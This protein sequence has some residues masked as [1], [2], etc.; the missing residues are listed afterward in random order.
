MQKVH[1]RTTQRVGRASVHLLIPRRKAD[2]HLA[3]HQ[4]PKPLAQQ[5]QER[6]A[7]SR[8]LSPR[9]V[10]PRQLP[11]QQVAQAAAHRIAP[12]YDRAPKQVPPNPAAGE[13]AIHKVAQR[14]RHVAH[15]RRLILCAR[16]AEQPASQAQR[17]LAVHQHAQPLAQ[18]LQERRAIRSHL[19]PRT[20]A[21]RQTAIHKVANA[22][23]HR[24]QRVLLIRPSRLPRHPAAR[25]LAVQKVAQRTRHRVLRNAEHALAPRAEAQ[26]H[27][28]VHQ[29][30][31]PLA[32]LLQER[33]AIRS[34][35]SP[36]AETTR[37]PTVH[38]VAK[39]PTQ[40]L[41]L[42]PQRLPRLLPSSPPTRKLTV[43]QV[44]Q[45]ARHRV[46]AR[47][48]EDPFAPRTKA[49]R[50]LAVHHEA[51]TLAEQLQERRPLRSHRMPRA[52]P[53]R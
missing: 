2:S 30:A 47:L 38:Q 37:K 32:Q 51:N 42:P 31:Q 33:P 20:E 50:Q 36:S 8:H 29:H 10:P 41:A 17:E 21:T 39:A 23:P 1:Q 19:H 11:V 52:P 12:A 45:R 14:A 34:H 18:L 46:V 40:R 5:L 35:L 26:S 6:R 49:Y 53:L 28:A 9:A 4:E 27:L 44:L 3:V 7:L 25:Q 43:Q 13:L 24:A 48:A 16:N 22:P 15:A